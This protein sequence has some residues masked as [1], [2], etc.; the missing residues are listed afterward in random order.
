MNGHELPVMPTLRAGS[1]RTDITPDEPIQL[2]GYGPGTLD[3]TSTG[4]H[5]P[6]SATALVL[7]DGTTTVA[8]VAVDLLN[9]S[10]ELTAAVREEASAL[11][12]DH[13]T[14]A[15]THTHAAPY[16]P[17]RF[18]EV[19]PLLSYDADTTDYVATVER[20][21]VDAISDAYDRSSSATLRVGRAT[22]DAVAV[23][24]RRADG[25]VDPELVAVVV[26]TDARDLLLLNFACHPVCTTADATLVAADWPG[27]LYERVRSETGMETLFLNGAAG[28]V[29]P[30]GSS[31]TRPDEAVYRYVAAVGEEVAETALDAVADARDADPLAVAGLT[32][33]R[34]TVELAFQATPTPEEMERR[35]AELTAEIDRLG[36]DPAAVDFHSLQD[37]DSRLASLF[38]DRWYLEEKRRLAECNRDAYETEL[39][40]VD[41]GP[42]G[43]LSI[44]GEAFV[45]HGLAFKA[46]ADADPLVVAGYAN[47][48]V[49][50]L[51][52]VE[53]FDEGGYEVRTCKFAPAGV[54]TF[55]EI[56]LD[57]VVE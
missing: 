17:G 56:A 53:A 5:S 32:V 13:V 27:A 25:P 9:V 7:D 49:G 39:A 51:P 41:V 54:E 47:E 38:R 18:L 46:A 8:V 34:R 44:P 3:R 40:Y 19:N 37:D 24:R 31:E 35:H 55:R 15:A 30:R 20:A 29:N 11:G 14:V 52:T 42:L 48:Y 43:F 21:V 2:S 4:V 26:E 6:L 23:N 28:D 45:E 57:L 1:A 10:R 16:V 50:Y 12:V 33:E 22:D 36:G